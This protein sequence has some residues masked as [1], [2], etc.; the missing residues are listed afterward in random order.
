MVIV[1]DNDIKHSTTL[2]GILGGVSVVAS[3][4]LLIEEVVACHLHT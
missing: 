4:D 3:C 2:F 1:V